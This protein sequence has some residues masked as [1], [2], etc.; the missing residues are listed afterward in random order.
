MHGRLQ[1]AWV[2]GQLEQ[3]DSLR[4]LPNPRSLMA[5]PSHHYGA[6]LKL[7]GPRPQVHLG[8]TPLACDSCHDNPMASVVGDYYPPRD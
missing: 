5:E 4:L 7:I 6:E 2:G 3:L 1:A 8:V